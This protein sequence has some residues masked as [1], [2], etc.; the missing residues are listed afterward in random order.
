MVPDRKCDSLLMER[1]FKHPLGDMAAFHVLSNGSFNQY[2]KFKLLQVYVCICKY[3]WRRWID[4]VYSPRK[5]PFKITEL[6][7]Y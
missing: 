1:L 7:K 6:V 5:M 2:R 4:F 3:L